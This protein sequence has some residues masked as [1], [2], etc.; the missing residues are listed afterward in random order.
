YDEI[1]MPLVPVLADMEMAAMKVDAKSLVAFSEF[2]STELD[3]LRENIFKIS[4]REFNIGSPKQVGEILGELN[5]ET[6]RKTATG[7]IS[8]SHDVLVELGET[9]DIAKFI[10]DYR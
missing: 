2:I 9:Y 5:I 7:Q 6:G 1:E 8:T 4:G 10:I 3:T